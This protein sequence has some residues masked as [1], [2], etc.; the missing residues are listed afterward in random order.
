MLGV[1]GDELKL[2][3]V[4][5]FDTKATALEAHC[6]GLCLVSNIS[7]FSIIS[8]GDIERDVHLISRFGLVGESPNVN[9]ELD[10]TLVGSDV[11]W[12]KRRQV[13]IR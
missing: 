7:K 4:N 12:R 6:H 11:R 10:R 2:A 8:V 5:W 13:K 9:K 1:N 3:F